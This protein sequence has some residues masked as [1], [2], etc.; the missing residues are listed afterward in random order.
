MEEF[1]QVVLKRGP[2]VQQLVINL[3]AVQDPKELREGKED[4]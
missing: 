2:R 3:V 4:L 1:L